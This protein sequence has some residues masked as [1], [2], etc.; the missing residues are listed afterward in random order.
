M[1]LCFFHN[2][3]STGNKGGQTAKGT[4]NE[5]IKIAVALSASGRLYDA[6]RNVHGKNYLFCVRSGNILACTGSRQV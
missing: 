5:K 3:F 1:C 6:K 4:H 2:V